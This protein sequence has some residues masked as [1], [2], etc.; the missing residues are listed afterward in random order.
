MSLHTTDL[1]D[2]GSR[3]VFCHGLFGQGKNWTQVGKQLATDHR[4][5]L[6]DM[7]HHGR[8]SWPE[9]FD[10]VDVADRVAQL[11]DAD[12]PVTLVGHS[13]GGKAAMVLA[14][15]HPELVARLCVV[16]MSPVDYGGHAGEFRRYIDAMQ[17][18]DLDAI[19]TRAEADAALVDAV[20]NTTVRSFLLQ[21]LRRDGDGWRWQANLEV[22]G[23]DLAE[24]GGWPEDDLAGTSPYE[25]PVLWVAGETSPYV[26]DEFAPAMERYFPRVRRVTVKGAGHW[27][28]S[29]QP[30]IFL[31]VLRRFVA[32]ED[33]TRLSS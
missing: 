25:G 3:V 31:E 22:L 26:S 30:E 15:R 33:R 20:P 13:M 27:V 32:A 29:E 24:L 12:D 18:M 1:G 21:N 10:Y 16:D 4:V 6:V 14:L 9:E 5:T 2:R 28:H 8:S 19:T 11:L 17:G 7:P 23:R